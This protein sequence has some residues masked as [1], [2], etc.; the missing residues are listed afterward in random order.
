M[1]K[2]RQRAL[3]VADYSVSTF[4]LIFTLPLGTTNL[5]LNERVQTRVL[6]AVGRCT[7]GE[8][9]L[10]SGRGAEELHLSG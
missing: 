7:R 3:S 1:P 9:F 6:Q 10:S 2:D 5:L 4:V 8:R